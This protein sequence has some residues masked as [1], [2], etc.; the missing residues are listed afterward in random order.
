[1]V[2]LA[3]QKRIAAEVLK[4][5]VGKVWI[6]P[7]ATEDV[8]E[9]ITREDVRGLI[10]EGVITVKQK[11]GVS[12]GRARVRANQKALGRRKGQGSRK[13]TKGARAN[14]KKQW[15]TKIRALRMRLKELRDD[16]YVDT[17]T[18]RKLYNK[19]NGGEFRSVAHLNDYIKAN[20]L[21]TREE[22]V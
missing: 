20:G 17:T 3:K 16:D 21:L 11:K 10:E 18:Y 8:A 13:G 4:V 12:R 1:M 22:T 19:A 9:A 2:N 6:D 7:E 5:G 14:K 15:I